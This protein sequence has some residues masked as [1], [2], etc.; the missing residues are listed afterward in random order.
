MKISKRIVIHLSLMCFV[1]Y[2]I[3]NVDTHNNVLAADTSKNDI[4]I[5]QVELVKNVENANEEEKWSKEYEQFIIK[6][7]K[8]NKVVNI[9]FE[10]YVYLKQRNK[11]IDVK[12][13]LVEYAPSK[14]EENNKEPGYPNCVADSKNVRTMSAKQST[15][16]YNTGLTRPPKSKYDKYNLLSVAKAGDL[17]YE[18]RGGK[19]FT[20]HISIVEGKF[21]NQGKY[22]IRLVE[23][24]PA[25]GV[26]RGIVDDVRVDECQVTLLRTVSSSKQKSSSV[27]F[28][29]SQIG[30]KYKLDLKK[31]TSK[32]EKDWYC[33]ELV[34]AAYKNQGVNLETSLGEPGVTPHDLYNS[35]LTYIINYRYATK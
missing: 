24:T 14:K 7:E 15:Y 30:K 3:T 11:Y 20:G 1:L 35:D 12:K 18:A 9:S 2:G 23:V 6:N 4:K 16:Y 17:V 13:Y 34:W 21:Y 19:G 33:S 31:N 32:A 27:A 10:E 29:V 28:A 25:Y 22:Y 8:E 26:Q 5:Q